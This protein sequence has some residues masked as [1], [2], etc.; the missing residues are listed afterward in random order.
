MQ[1]LLVGI[2]KAAKLLTHRKEML[3]VATAKCR[4]SGRGDASKQHCFAKTCA[5]VIRRKRTVGER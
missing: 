5:V 2:D 3:K 1:E 4:A